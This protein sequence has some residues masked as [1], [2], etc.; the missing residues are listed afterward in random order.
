MSEKKIKIFV[1]KQQQLSINYIEEISIKRDGKKVKD[2]QILKKF[3]KNFS[4]FSDHNH[5]ILINEDQ[6]NYHVIMSKYVT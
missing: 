3:L 6:Q 4:Q 1:R 5:T 2:Y